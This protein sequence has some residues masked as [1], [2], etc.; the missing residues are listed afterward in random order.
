MSRK[1]PRFKKEGI[2]DLENKE[3]EK[4]EQS[5]EDYDAFKFMKSKK[6]AATVAGVFFLVGFLASWL[7]QPSMTGMIIS[8][9]VPANVQEIGQS[10]VDFLN[11][12][13]VEGGGVTLVSVEDGGELLE[14]NTVYNGNE[15]PVHMTLDGE[16]IILGGVGAVNM[17]EYREQAA[18]QPDA[19]QPPAGS[20]VPKS[21]NPVVNV[22]VMSYCPYGLQMQKAVI[23]AMELLGDKADISINFV[24]YLMHGEKEMIDNNNQYCIQKDQPEKFTDYLRCFV[25][26]GSH[27]TCATETGIDT[28]NLEACIAELE[29]TY[30]LTGAFENS[31]SNYPPYPVEDE[32][33][34]M[35]GV[36]GSPSVVINGVTVSVSRSAEAFKQAV[37]DAFIEAP[38]ECSTVLDTNQE[39]P[40]FGPVGSGTVSASASTASC[41]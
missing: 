10:G 18:Q 4:K 16:Y 15:I 29:E 34:S 25:E 12:Y 1:R 23:P 38:E 7:V 33:N 28:A 20:D 11:E 24:N 32:L 17:A 40:S 19:P 22:F 37:C 27:D 8:S 6:Q 35:Y 21:D 5:S 30:D 26:K 41:E 9:D 14:V 31:D 13:F 3:V 2:E 36:R 39:Q